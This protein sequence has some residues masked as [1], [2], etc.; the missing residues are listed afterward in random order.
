MNCH[1]EIISFRVYKDFIVDAESDDKVIA[2]TEQVLLANEVDKND[3]EEEYYVSLN[4][5]IEE[6]Y[7]VTDLV[8]SILS[9]TNVDDNPPKMIP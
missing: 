7:V 2:V 8:I 4:D 5:I 1:H 9:N 3:D 6:L